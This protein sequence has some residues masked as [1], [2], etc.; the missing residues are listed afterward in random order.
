[1]GRAQNLD[2]FK[3]AMRIHA[4]AMFN[5]GYGDRDGNIF[6]VYNALLPERADGH[7]WSGTVPGN[8][9]DTLWREYRPFD[10]LPTVENPKSGFIQN[11]NSDPFQT[12]T[13]EDNPDETAFSENYSI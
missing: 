13:G 10:E 3:D 12:T 11:C 4:L 5:T 1:M 6:Y 9:R 7:D 8:T 2:E